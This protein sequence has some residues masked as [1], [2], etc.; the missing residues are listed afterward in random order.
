MGQLKPSMDVVESM[1]V[2]EQKKN[3]DSFALVDIDDPFGETAKVDD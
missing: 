2:L 3:N 1:D